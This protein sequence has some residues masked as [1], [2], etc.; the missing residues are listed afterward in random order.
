MQSFAQTYDR[1]LRLAAALEG[2][3]AQPGSKIAILASNGP[4]YFEL[5][6]AVCEAGMVEVPVNA[7]F[8][9]T[10]QIGFLARI[11]PE[12]L[13]VTPEFVAR[14]RDLQTVVTSIQHVVGIGDGHGLT[15]DYERL[16]AGADPTERSLGDVDELA[17]ICATSGTSGKSKAV[18]HTQ[19]TTASA[20]SPL[21]ERFEID[22]HAHFVTGLAMYFATAYS[23]W[24]ASFIA[25]ARHTIMPTYSPGGWVDLVEQTGATHGFL[26]PTPVY[27]MMDAGIDMGRLRGLRYLSMGGALCDPGRLRA[28]TQT[29]GA[30]VAVQLSM[31]ELGAGTAMLGS[32]FLDADGTLSSRH[33]AAGRPMRGLQARIVDDDD[34]PLPESG[35]HEGELEFRGPMV[36]PGYLGDEAAN[37]EAGHGTWFRTGDVARIDEDGFIFIVDR[38]KDLIVSGGINIAPSEVEHVLMA[39]PAVEAAGV[40][41]VSDPT[42]GEAVQ[43][44][45][46]L[47]DGASVTTDDLMSWCREHLASVK[48]PRSIVVVDELPMSSTGKLLRRQ[49]RAQFDSA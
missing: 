21:I 13:L 19:R 48:K 22:E 29:L 7:R 37:R 43:A 12:I 40:C 44:V 3:G 31:T 38:K 1:T 42:Y 10:E 49:L 45:V 26:G 27:M 4:W 34:E 39:H 46:K 18:Q 14:A 20:Y 6:F 5:H 30:R 41:G 35:K 8:T 47:R 33:R 16:L 32:E 28:I 15:L 23:G 9:L 2:L 25:G 11:A 17:L 36:S 24:T